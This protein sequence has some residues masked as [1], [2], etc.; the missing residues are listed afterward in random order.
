MLKIKKT[1][2][3]FAVVL[4]LLFVGA[5][6]DAAKHWGTP[7]EGC[8]LGLITNEEQY[9]FGDLINL[10]VI[11]QNLTRKELV[12][13]DGGHFPYEISL[14]LPN[15]KP[16]PLSLWGQMESSSPKAYVRNVS[17]HL[18]AGETKTDD[19]S[20][21]NRRFD[22]TLEGQ[23]TIVVRRRL[24]SESDPNAWIEVFSN[25]VV[26]TLGPPESKPATRPEN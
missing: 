17:I 13:G 14:T 15:G 21:L 16:A 7:L 20:M 11:L 10:Q 3:F 5:N 23:Y 4:M 8:R 1:S 12:F 18:A 25:S 24:P 2:F 22:M 9:H 26:I 19:L 6:G